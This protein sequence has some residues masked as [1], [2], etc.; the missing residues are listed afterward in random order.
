MCNEKAHVAV[1]RE[2]DVDKKS[3]GLSFAGITVAVLHPESLIRIIWDYIIACSLVAVAI[4]LPLFI[5]F[6]L[7]ADPF[8][9]CSVVMVVIDGVFVLDVW[10]SFRCEFALTQHLP[11]A[12]Y[13]YFVQAGH[14]G[15]NGTAGPRLRLAI[16]MMALWYG[17]GG[18]SRCIFSR[19]G[20][21]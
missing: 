21:W 12:R 14:W 9:A 15:T 20:C 5:G 11:Y 1:C 13:S 10:M 18:R 3:V 7:T 8:S 4:V 19:A 6:D 2:Y 16:M 17:A